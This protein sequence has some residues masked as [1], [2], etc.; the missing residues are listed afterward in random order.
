[1]LHCNMSVVP[2]GHAAGAGASAAAPGPAHDARGRG[3]AFPARLFPGRLASLID[4]AGPSGPALFRRRRKCERGSGDGM[5][6]SLL[7]EAAQVLL[8]RA[9]GSWLK[10][11]GLQLAKR[12]GMKRAIVAT[13]RGLSVILHRMWTEGSDFRFTRQQGASA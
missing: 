1:M 6:R 4:L 8:T 9:S 11:W 13:A 3:R 7:F 5:L 10:A 12:R 2:G